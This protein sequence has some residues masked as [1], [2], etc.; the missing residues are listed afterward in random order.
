MKSKCPYCGK[1]G[2]VREMR[3]RLGEVMGEKYEYLAEAD[4]C[5]TCRQ[6][7]IMDPDKAGY[8]RALAQLRALKVGRLNDG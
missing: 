4:V 5:Y 2:I 1:D 8:E 3:K 6:V 7:W